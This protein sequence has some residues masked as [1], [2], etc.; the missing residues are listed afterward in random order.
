MCDGSVVVKSH[1]SGLVVL[2][3]KLELHAEWD[4]L[5]PRAEGKAAR[6]GVVDR[7]RVELSTPNRGVR[8]QVDIAT[9]HLLAR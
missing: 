8:R 1:L 5:R 2:I 6:L 9:G 4:I 7:A 3:T